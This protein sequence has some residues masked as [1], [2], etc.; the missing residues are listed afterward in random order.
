MCSTDTPTIFTD[1]VCSKDSHEIDAIVTITGGT[2]NVV[3]EQTCSNM[4]SEHGLNNDNLK[5]NLRA[6]LKFDTRN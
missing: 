2:A 5:S 6:L 4:E 1:V 3:F